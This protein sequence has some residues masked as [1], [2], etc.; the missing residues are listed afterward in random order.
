M[1]NNYR[2]EYSVINHNLKKKNDMSEYDNYP[3]YNHTHIE[4]RITNCEGKRTRIEIYRVYERG[5]SIF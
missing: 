4:Y 2:T 1:K 3:Y 5:F